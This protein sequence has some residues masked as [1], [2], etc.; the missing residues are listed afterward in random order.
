M[1]RQ[2]IILS[3]KPFNFKEE[4][5]DKE[6]SG[7]NV[8]YVESLETY[9]D[10]RISGVDVYKDKLPYDQMNTIGECPAVYLAEFGRKA[11]AKGKAEEY[12]QSVDYLKPIELAK[13]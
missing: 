12:L 9:H 10:Y 11:T 4:E 13:R 1:S 3:A 8:Q 6:I 7:I 5:T 2:I